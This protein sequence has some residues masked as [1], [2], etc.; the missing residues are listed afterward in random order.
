VNPNLGPR[1]PLLAAVPVL[2]TALSA[3]VCFTYCHEAKFR[4][5][6]VFLAALLAA[7]LTASP[8]LLTAATNP[9]LGQ[10]RARM[11]E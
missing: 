9:N 11:K 1:L 6:P 8:A 10:H 3:L 5:T 4:S 7:L 2:L